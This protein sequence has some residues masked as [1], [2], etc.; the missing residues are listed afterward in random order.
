LFRVLSSE[1]VYTAV[2]RTLSQIFSKMANALEFLGENPFK[3]SAYRK[4][5]KVLEDYP[6]DLEEVMKRGGVQALMEIPGI[7]ERM[8]R[9][10]LEYLETGKIKGYEEVRSQVSEPLLDLME[11]QGVGPKTLKL[12]Y[13]LLKVR[14][15]ED[16]KRVIEDGSLERLPGMGRKRVENIRKGLE[17]YERMSERIPLGV[18]YPLVREIVLEMG[19]P[20][21]VESI[22]AC[23]SF[24][25]MKETVGDLDIL[26]TGSD[27]PTIIDRF[28]HLRGVTRVLAQGETKGSVIFHDRYQ[29]DLRVVPKEC[30]GS[31]LQYFTGSK[32]HN[33][34]LRTIAKGLGL[35]ISEYGVFSGEMRL[36]GE[37]EEEVYDLLGLAWIPPELREDWGEIEASAARR[38]PSLI[39]YRDI[40][41]DLHVHSRYSDG[42]M[43]LEEL[44]A[45]AERR[46]LEY[47]G[48]CDHSRTARYARG[49]DERRLLEKAQQIRDLN[50]RRPGGPYLLAGAEVDI[51][52]DGSLDYPDELLRQLDLVIGA[53]H[54]WRRGEDVTPRILKAMENP[55]LDIVAHPTGRLISTR[56]GYKVDVD[57][58][59]EKAAERGIALE[60]NAYYDRL[61]LNDLNTRKARSKGVRLAIGTDAH[62]P[63][64]LWMIDLGV[65]VAR[66]GW[67]E[68]QDIL[69]TFSYEELLNFVR[70]RRGGAT[71][72]PSP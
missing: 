61:D 14:T 48:V 45:E 17:L 18:A 1:E 12:A 51:L 25:R 43:G 26:C 13:D 44:M 16:F 65:G 37:R 41:G 63:G 29:V 8:A 24:R 11:V 31:A 19:L 23:G 70:K 55:Y 72:L 28:V 68:R 62:N 39:G 52:P 6:E 30:Y 54:S 4:A 67:C 9:K 10:I 33:I 7:G 27:G 47:I 57:A 59:I 50:R 3:V 20:S 35:K 53:I 71:H 40:R 42:T 32:E 36:G 64:Q 56:E 5:S 60:I 49:L 15:L 2:N 34:H 69:N 22:S 21:M 66:R 58:V 46:G 38:L